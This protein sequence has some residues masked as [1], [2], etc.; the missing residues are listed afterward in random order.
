MQLGQLRGPNKGSYHRDQMRRQRLPLIAGL[1]FFHIKL[2]IDIVGEK[3]N[4]QI[5]MI[6]NP[7]L[8]TSLE[9]Q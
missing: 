5:R 8:I 6:R 9:P 4:I 2:K 7:R 1:A 3:G